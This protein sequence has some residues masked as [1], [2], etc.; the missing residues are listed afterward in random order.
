MFRLEAELERY[1][2]R[3]DNLRF[4]HQQEIREAQIRKEVEE[5]YKVQLEERKRVREEAKK[6]LEQARLEAEKAAREKLE[7]ERKAEE[8][9]RKREEEQAKRL[10]REIRLKVEAEKQAEEAEKKAKARME[11]SLELL[12]KTKMVEKFDHLLE[13]TKERLQVPEKPSPSQRA[14]TKSG[15]RERSKYDAS[16]GYTI[17]GDDVP[18]RDQSSRPGPSKPAG[19]SYATSSYRPEKDTLSPSE[20]EWEKV[21]RPVPVQVP[22]PPS[23]EFDSEEEDIPHPDFSQ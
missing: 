5:N 21:P 7:T 23:F 11:E 14:P 2:A 3:D 12:M 10:E 8:A 19:H 16:D 6:E 1:R 13:T 9:V 4:T 15:T 22:D 20:D 17:D 18:Y